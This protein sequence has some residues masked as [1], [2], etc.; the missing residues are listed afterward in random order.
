MNKKEFI[1][2]IRNK[3][4]ARQKDTDFW[5]QFQG[6]SNEVSEG[7]YAEDNHFIYELIQ[8]AEDTESKE[9]EHI[10]EFTLEEEGLLVY[11]NE[12]GF[13]EEQID[14]ICSFKK[15]TKVKEKNKGFIGEKGIGFKS[16]F[17]VSDRPAISSNGYRFYFRR[18]DEKG[19]TE[20]IIPHWIDDDLLQSYPEK[21]QD[22]THTTLFLPFDQS[23]KEER[24]SALRDSI[25]QIEP[26]L[27][28]FLNRL[29]SIRIYEKNKELVNTTKRNEKNENISLVTINN[30]QAKDKY[31][32]F[33]KTIDVDSELEEVSGKDGKRKD[34]KKREIILA[35]PHEKNQ[36]EEDRI[37][38]FLP[39]NL[40]SRLNFIIQADFILQ[41]G[42]ENIAK[43][44]E[45]NK[46]QLEQIQSFIVNEVIDEFQKHSKLS[47]KYLSYFERKNESDNELINSMYEVLINRLKDEKVILG[48]DKQWHYPKDI[49]L[50]TDGTKIESKYLKILFGN[51]YEQVD[52]KFVLPEDLVD[53]FHIN[54]LSKQDIVKRIS[55]Y[56][57]EISLDQLEEDIVYGLTVFL[58]KYLYVDSSSKKYDKELYSLIK[59]RLPIIPKYPTKHRFYYAGSIY[60]SEEYKPS[61]YLENMV[62][63]SASDFENFNFLSPRYYGTQQKRIEIFLRKILDEQKEDNNKKSIE[64]MSKY[65]RYV[66]TYLRQR[67]QVHYREIFDF[68]LKNQKDN[69]DRIAKIPLILTQS[70]TFYSAKDNISIYFPAV[71]LDPSF[72]VIHSDLDAILKENNEYKD[73]IEKVFRIKEAD[74]HNIILD[75]YLPWFKTNRKR[76]NS[77]NDKVLIEY[78]ATI[79]KHFSEFEREDRKKI[80]EALCFLGTNNNERY[81]SASDLYLDSD[82]AESYFHTDSIAQYITDKS[83]FNFLD[84]S[85]RKIFEQCEERDLKVFLEAFPFNTNKLADGDLKN[86]LRFTSSECSLE[87]SIQLFKIIVNSDDFRESKYRIE[88]LSDIRLYSQ[89]H[90]LLP[91]GKLFLNQLDELPLSYLDDA[92]RKDINLNTPKIRQYFQNQNKIDPFVE[93]LTACENMNEAQKIYRYLDYAC[94]TINTNRR[95][96]VI[97][98]EKVKIAFTK[99]PLILGN[100]GKKYY[101]SDVVWTPQKSAEN[102]MALSEI[103]PDDLQSFFVNKVRISQH[104]GIKQIVDQIKGIKRKDKEYFD[105]LVD[106]SHLIISR[107]EIEDY[108]KSYDNRI[109]GKYSNDPYENAIQFLGKSEKIFI[110]DNHVKIGCENLYFNDLSIQVPS[111]LE[112]A[113]LTLEYYGKDA[114][115]GLVK[116]LGIQVFS[117]LG[118]QYKYKSIEQ[119]LDIKF[120][121]DLLDFAYDLLFTKHFDEYKQLEDRG[122]ELE[123]INNIQGVVLSK[124]IESTLKIS[125]I[126]ITLSDEKYYINTTNNELVAIDEKS[127]CKAIAHNIGFI[128]DKDLKDFMDEV[129][130]DGMNKE[131]YYLEENIKEKQNFYLSIS[132][133]TKEYTTGSV[134][135]TQKEEEEYQFDDDLI[136]SEEEEGSLPA[137]PQEEQE[138]LRQEDS[139]RQIRKYESDI[140]DGEQE[141]SPVAT[142]EL[143]AKQERFLRDQEKKVKK[144]YQQRHRNTLTN[145]R[146]RNKQSA[147]FR[148]GDVETKEF[149]LRKDQYAGHCQIC[150]FTFKTKN[151]HNYCERF[152]WSDKRKN[153]TVADLIYPGNS[154][155]LCGKCYS[156]INGGGDFKAE[157]LEQVSKVDDI[158]TFVKRFEGHTVKEVPE[159]FEEHIDFDDMYT[160]PVRLNQ[161]N[162][163]MY[164]TEDHLIE[165]FAFLNT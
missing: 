119:Y 18:K 16:V 10:L 53:N 44:N 151:G 15:S 38:A 32:I 51:T 42:R 79:I 113:V 108:R 156:I 71:N 132:D 153:N 124:I 150:G 123:K 72:A 69:I 106:L 121:R 111:D 84:S 101:A 58:A 159:I 138:R 90:E 114:F 110:T 60:L 125:D 54:R 30:T 49:F 78:T 95:E 35:F 56:F 40:R 8:N 133:V 118:K 98:A 17:K 134:A 162:E 62:D 11:N 85:Y 104:R 21:F 137:T 80:K 83:F 127:V 146:S 105:L 82:I 7:I 27:L 139:H 145:T 96:S 128:S 19:M 33:K 158:D 50:I 29:D 22:N 102:L 135:D 99:K 67:L 89:N 13:N 66:Q 36:T 28:L 129:L 87:D 88:G 5:Q 157:F 61:L 143:K 24:L 122:G 115:D 103:Y 120:Y 100:D 47:Y 26:I 130:I 155:C 92:Y 14:A 76:R 34:V 25:R 6:L 164:F 94:N 93:Y 43:D 165:L 12:V 116:I 57:I 142:G 73:F 2:S 126:E 97:T 91:I 52:E 65:P 41:S 81:L 154:L 46:W 136:E 4:I 77:E 45:W 131:D 20:Y 140:K 117:K 149:F 63:C 55:E 68:F 160:L 39:T 1:D 163:Y 23:K 161:K 109:D 148:S 31:Y 152:T 9:K 64:F 37:F 74:I 48:A 147:S 75:Q 3:W 107:D 59:Q 144:I 86:F 141:T 70:D 112:N